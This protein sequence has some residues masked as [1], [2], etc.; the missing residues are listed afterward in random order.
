[1]NAFLDHFI[2]FQPYPED[3]EW[4]AV[5]RANSP[6]QPKVATLSVIAFDLSGGFSDVLDTSALPGF[7]VPNH[8]DNR[9]WAQFAF[10]GQ[11]LILPRL[12]AGNN[13]PI[14]AYA[15]DRQGLVVTLS[16]W[17]GTWS[18]DYRDG[19]N[20]SEPYGGDSWRIKSNLKPGDN[21]GGGS[22][23]SRAGLVETSLWSPTDVLDAKWSDFP[24]NS[25]RIIVGSGNNDGDIWIAKRDGSQQDRLTPVWT[26]FPPGFIN[27][28]AIW[29]VRE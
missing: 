7:P 26:E 22:L 15:F 13:P 5:R 9:F 16:A 4:L 24:D 10:S 3:D 11:T 28:D 19:S 17:S 1:V 8:P 6:G 27:L 21:V 29:I 23:I 25:G 18:F 14:E 12:E 2:G 20:I